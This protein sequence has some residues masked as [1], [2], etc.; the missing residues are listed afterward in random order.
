[1]TLN[2]SACSADNLDIEELLVTKHDQNLP[3]MNLDGLN[4]GLRLAMATDICGRIYSLSCP[5]FILTPNT[6]LSA[7]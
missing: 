6:K 2:S 4:F 5:Q 3:K 7:T 1:M